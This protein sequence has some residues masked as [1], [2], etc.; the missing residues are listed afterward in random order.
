M[1]YSLGYTIVHHLLCM[2]LCVLNLISII[3]HNLTYVCHPLL[4]FLSTPL[5]QCLDLKY[6]ALWQLVCYII[7]TP[8]FGYQQWRTWRRWI[9]GIHN[10]ETPHES[11]SLMVLGKPP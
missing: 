4:L 3:H 2:V 5:F 8:T 11:H 10:W 7:T 9:R 6:E 1:Y